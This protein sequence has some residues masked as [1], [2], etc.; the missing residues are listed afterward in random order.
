MSESIGIADVDELLSRLDAARDGYP[1]TNLD[2][3]LNVAEVVPYAASSI[4]NPSASRFPTP[5]QGFALQNWGPPPC[6]SSMPNPY[7]NPNLWG[8]YLPSAHTLHPQLPQAP[9]APFHQAPPGSG[10]W[11]VQSPPTLNAPHLPSPRVGGDTALPPANGAS[12]TGALQLLLG[13]SNA[14]EAYPSPPSNATSKVDKSSP[15]AGH[16]IL[17]NSEPKKTPADDDYLDDDGWIDAAIAEMNE[18]KA[19]GQPDSGPTSKYLS[20]PA[21]WSSTPSHHPQDTGNPQ[22]SPELPRNQHLPP[23]TQAPSLPPELLEAHTN[24]LK[25]TNV[26]ELHSVSTS[27]VERSEPTQPPVPLQNRRSP[28]FLREGESEGH[29]GDRLTRRPPARPPSASTVR[30]PKLPPPPAGHIPPPDAQLTS[31]VEPPTTTGPSKFIK[32]GSFPRVSV[33]ALETNEER[34]LFSFREFNEMQSTIFQTAYKTDQNMVVSAP[35]GSGKTTVFE[36]AF[37]RMLQFKSSAYTPLAI[38]MAPT[39]ALCSERYYDWRER[40][41][42]LNVKCIELTGDTEIYNI[43]TYTESADL[44]ITTIHT[45]NE[46]RGATLEVVVSRMKKRGDGLRFVAVSATVPNID[47]VARWIGSKE[48][49]KSQ[50]RNEDGDDEPMP[51]VEYDDIEQMPKA[52]VFKFGDEYRP[53]PLTLHAVGVDAPNEFALGGRLDK[54][55]WRLLNQHTDGLPTLVFCPTRK[56]CQAT[57]EHIFQEYQNAATNRTRLP[58]GVSDNQRVILK[59]AKIQKWTELGIAVHHA[60]LDLLDRRTI[61]QAFRTSQ[62]HL[63][64]AT[65]TLA[66][67][68]NLP[69][70]L[71][72]IKGT[73]CWA[74]QGFREYSDIDIQQMMGRAGR[75]QFDN[76]GTV[77]IMCNNTKLHK[78]QSMMHSKTILESYLHHHLTEHINSEIGLGTIGS[79]QNA[80]EWLRGIRIR[81][82]PKHYQ[83]TMTKDHTKSWDATLDRFVETSVSDLKKH[84]FI[85]DDPEVIKEKTED[86]SEPK[87]LLP[88]N[89]GTIMSQNFISYRT[90]CHIVSMD[91]DS[92]LRSLLELLAGSTEFSSLRIRQGD[93]ALLNTL[94]VH[95]DIKYHLDTPAKTYADKVFLLAQVTFG[96]VNLDEFST[97]TENT[98]PLQTQI[99]IFNVAPRLARAIFNVTCHKQYGRAAVA[100]IELCHTV[101]GKAWEDTSAVFRQIDKIGP[102]SITVLESNGIH[103]F[104]DLLKLQPSRIEMWLNRHPPFGTEVL[105]RV[106]ALPRFTIEFTEEGRSQDENGYP[107]VQLRLQIRNSGQLVHK[108]TKGGAIR[109]NQKRTKA[110]N[111]IILTVTTKDNRF[112]DKRAIGTNRLSD[113]VRE[114]G[115]EATLYYPDERIMCIAGVEEKSGL[116]RTFMYKPRIPADKFP[117]REEI[118]ARSNAGEPGSSMT[119]A[120]SRA[121]RRSKSPLF[122]GVDDS[123]GDELIDLTVP[124][125]MKSNNKNKRPR[126]VVAKPK[127]RKLA[128]AVKS[129]IDDEAIDDDEE[130]DDDD[131]DDDEDGFID[132][133]D[134]PPPHKSSRS[135]GKTNACAERT[136]KSKRAALPVGQTS[137]KSSSSTSKTLGS[138]KP[139]CNRSSTILDDARGDIDPGQKSIAENEGA[140]L[141]E[142]LQIAKP[143]APPP[144]L[145]V[146]EQFQE[147][148]GEF[149]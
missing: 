41:K 134:R 62:L 111:L 109:G 31:P 57:A 103:T 12:P 21:Q 126:E 135:A 117:K 118:I 129:F 19:A 34:Q 137:S 133:G 96:N 101:H 61:E 52:R 56:A 42:A 124:R 78:Y 76:S 119:I 144:V 120:P 48:Q 140:A 10:F 47:D 112:I 36:L 11:P 74:G 142:A 25:A 102:K 55:L 72:V 64:I 40:F 7:N 54:E 3:C 58:W 51:P 84:D 16:T 82:N 132:M 8:D 95:K 46:E 127:T 85:T 122:L 28:Y 32:K 88:T 70:H 136:S 148:F 145:S 106:T 105:E 104:D 89:L 63:L 4:M 116:S 75:P 13:T 77:V 22:P 79:L 83:E 33:Y 90:M 92:S 80:Q 29:A 141:P 26:P 53:V 20:P 99:L 128:L 86:G 23:L 97:K 87:E 1:V 44:I 27:V 39:K 6:P 35:T 98:S 91:P 121:T 59:D 38:Y 68:V 139:A 71:V 81:Q 123:D 143:P 138:A 149:L 24:L 15:I 9:L 18:A 60:G 50:V 2:P 43:Q 113:R 146:D 147:W 110:Y 65:S 108:P 107:T 114:F 14:Q 37:L 30:F 93:R 100:A 66:V 5:Y 125:E 69:A 115:L 67:G 49:G 94:R 17:V 130:P 131:M 45:L 73:S